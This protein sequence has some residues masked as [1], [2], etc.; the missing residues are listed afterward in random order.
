MS[1][2]VGCLLS[3]TTDLTSLYSRSWISGC[4]ANSN[5]RN[6]AV[7]VVCKHGIVVNQSIANSLTYS[8]HACCQHITAEYESLFL[9]ELPLNQPLVE[10]SNSLCVINCARS[11]GLPDFLIMTIQYL[12]AY[13]YY[14]QK[15]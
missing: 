14:D 2:Q 11:N 6:R 7:L 8:I 15:S 13:K 3:S 4:F 12:L 10:K 5:R 1:S 9:I